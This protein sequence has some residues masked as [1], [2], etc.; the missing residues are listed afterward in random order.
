MPS[1]NIDKYIISSQVNVHQAMKKLD[2]SHRKILFVVK[3]DFLL[4]GT[5]ISQK[6]SES[7]LQFKISLP[8]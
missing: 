1:N 4:F 7:C 8:P 5:K 2:D 3:D 6:T